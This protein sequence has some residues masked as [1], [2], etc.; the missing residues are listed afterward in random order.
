LNTLNSLQ[1]G[2]AIAALMVVVHHANIATAAFV[3]PVPTRAASIFDLGYLGVDFFFVLS[4]FIIYYTTAGLEPTAASTAAF[5]RKRLTRIFV[6]YWPIGVGLAVAYMAMAGLSASNRSW[7]WFAT[8]T[9]LPS[10]NPPALSV[11][12][13]LQHELVFY[14]LF[15]V[16]FYTRAIL[17]LTVVWAAAI[18]SA[19]VL[20]VGLDGPLKFL[21]APINLEFIMGIATAFLVTSPRKLPTLLLTCG[22]ILPLA[23]FFALGA[24]R[25]I[26]P[27]VGLAVAF[28]VFV[29]CRMEMG[30]RV[31]IA[32]IFVL[33]GDASYAIYLIHTP[34]LSLFLRLMRE[35]PRS[36]PGRWRSCWR[37]FSAR[38]PA[39]HIT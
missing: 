3:G 39:L 12:W 37:P 7:G 17:P 18:L 14:A 29:V 30:R 15:G 10:W 23:A 24:T 8:L 31:S 11:A 25:D 28:V 33:L 16:M 5:A 2:R 4:G 20:R 26:S 36:R 34:L 21:V 38:S 35:F 13:T 9:L 19:A 6:P 1:A 22:V 32:V 27:L